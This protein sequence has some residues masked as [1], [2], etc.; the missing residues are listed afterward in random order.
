MSL[1]NALKDVRYYTHMAEDEGLPGF[2]AESVHQTWAL[3]AAM[4][5]S[6][7]NCNAVIQAFEKLTGVVARSAGT[8]SPKA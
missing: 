5:L 6:D 2:L 1:A 8:Q 7:L 4:G 3:A